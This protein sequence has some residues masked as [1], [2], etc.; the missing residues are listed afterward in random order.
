MWGWIEQGGGF[1]MKED[2]CFVAFYVCWVE[3]E[4]SRVARA[5]LELDGFQRGEATRRDAS[6]D[7]DEDEGINRPTDELID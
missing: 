1:W 3:C 6:K 2:D 4:A 7:E 5:G